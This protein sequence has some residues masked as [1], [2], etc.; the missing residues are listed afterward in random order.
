MPAR[1]SGPDLHENLQRWVAEGL[2]D[3]AQAS[4]IERAESGTEQRPPRRLTGRTSFVVEALG[5]L[6]GAL[7]ILAGF[8]AVNQLWPD[9]PFGAQLA[10]AATAAVALGAV[11]AA[12]GTGEPALAR[13]RSVLWLMSTGCLAAFVGLLA[14]QVWDLHPIGAAAVT[15]ATTTG[16]A[17]VLWYRSR[18]P[19][20]H[21]ATFAA[22]AAT[23]GTAVAWT[24]PEQTNWAPGLAVWLLSAAWG[25]AT[26]RGYLRPRPG[27]LCTV[28]GLLVG[29][30]TTMAVPAGHA[31]ALATVAG[32]LVGGIVLRRVS[33][34][35]AG[36]IGVIQV[37]PQTAAR[38]LPQSLAAPLAILAVGLVL[39]GAALWLARQPRRPR[40]G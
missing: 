20:Q 38:Y 17:A 37:V 15:A 23:V 14:A 6:G 7:A 5:Y 3:P 33:L 35:I 12:T 18:A 8:I 26:Y 28:V 40:P 19:L 34:L 2:L 4:R 22:A 36:A 10:F 29:A 1:L 39:L 32:L 30:Q 24:A 9:I 25:Y 11:G 21:L 16:Y 31:L 13:L 27:Y